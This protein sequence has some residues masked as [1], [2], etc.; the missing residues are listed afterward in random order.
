MSLQLL[1]DTAQLMIGY[2][3]GDQ[4][5]RLKV[6]PLA[7]AL[8]LFQTSSSSG[9]GGDAQGSSGSKPEAGGRSASAASAAAAAVATME[10]LLGR[11]LRWLLG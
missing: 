7:E 1:E 5:A 2:G 3:S 4:A 10:A 6:M 8:D 11:R 9:S